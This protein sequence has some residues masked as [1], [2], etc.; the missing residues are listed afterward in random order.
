MDQVQRA[1][2]SRYFLNLKININGLR[3]I[4]SN[5][6]GSNSSGRSL[7]VG[8][9][10]IMFEQ[11]LARNSSSKFICTLCS[12]GQHFLYKACLTSVTDQ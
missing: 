11:F 12:H 9:I 10:H 7:G 1:Y 6:D 4:Q 8:P 2:F 5:F 3:N